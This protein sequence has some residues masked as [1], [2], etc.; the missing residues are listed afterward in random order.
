M[1][2]DMS[3]RSLRRLH[4]PRASVDNMLP[5]QSNRPLLLAPGRM[6]AILIQTGNTALSGMLQWDKLQDRIPCLDY[7]LSQDNSS[8]LPMRLFQIQVF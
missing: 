1:V 7:T 5:C 4:G 6:W 8:V 3:V 2:Q